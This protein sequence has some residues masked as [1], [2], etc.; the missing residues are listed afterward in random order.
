VK[1][2]A[3]MA[4]QILTEPGSPPAAAVDRSTAERWIELVLV[5][6]VAVSQ[7]LLLSVY[8]VI[9][10]VPNSITSGNLRYVYAC[11]QEASGLLVLWYVLRRT[12][13]TFSSLGLRA[14]VRGGFAGLG[15]AVVGSAA[16]LLSS[17]LIEVVHRYYFGAYVTRT[18]PALLFPKAS[19]IILIPF[20]LLNCFFE[21]AIVRA[22]L[23]TELSELT[24]S[25]SWAAIASILVQTSYHTYQGWL[26]VMG[27]AAT[28]SVF[29]FYYARAQKLFPLYIAHVLV[30]ALAM[31]YLFAR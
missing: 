15:L 27:L 28:F 26:P 4:P 3:S 21:E 7:P 31:V 12:G 13:R 24:G 30:D 22:Y 25:M 20:L 5:L 11:V 9:F 16:Y 8:V 18:S 17:V 23:M 19:W 29:S 6:F 1:W 2:L 10:G 14:S